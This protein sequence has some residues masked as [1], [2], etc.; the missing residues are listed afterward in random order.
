MLEVEGTNAAE[1]CE[2]HAMTVILGSDESCAP[3]P[4]GDDDGR[5]Q[6]GRRDDIAVVRSAD[7]LVDGR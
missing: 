3:E 5:G 1:Q 7:A 4:A 2:I 6:P